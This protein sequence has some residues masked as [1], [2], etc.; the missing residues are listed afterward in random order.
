[1]N[2]AKVLAAILTVGGPAGAAAIPDRDLV[3]NFVSTFY[4]WYV[5]IATSDKKEPSST[6]AIQKRYDCFDAPL[7]SALKKDAAAQTA[8]PTEIV[9]LDFDPFLNSILCYI[10][11]A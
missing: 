5:P 11:G 9:G 6:I 3:R 8:S 2:R 7:L 1:M 4:S 10:N